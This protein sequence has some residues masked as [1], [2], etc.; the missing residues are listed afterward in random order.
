MLVEILIAL[1]L[2]AI[3]T[4]ITASGFWLQALEKEIK[5]LKARIQEL[6]EGVDRETKQD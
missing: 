2:A 5:G 1:I 3:L 4:A 6:G